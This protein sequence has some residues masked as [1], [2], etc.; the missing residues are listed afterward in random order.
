M[1][2][3]VLENLFFFLLP[4][5][6]YL[7]YVAYTENEW[8]GLGSVIRA[9]PLVKLFVAG[10]V[11]MLT[12]LILLSTSSPNSPHDVYVPPIVEDG[13]LRPGHRAPDAPQ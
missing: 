6:L 2:R 13:K 5:L 1:T 10:A 4:T 8:P 3:I 9:A 7:A 11:L 12:T